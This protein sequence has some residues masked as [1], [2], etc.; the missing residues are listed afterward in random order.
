VRLQTLSNLFADKE[1]NFSRTT[2]CR[3]KGWY[4]P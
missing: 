2:Q 4:Y 1:G 3:K